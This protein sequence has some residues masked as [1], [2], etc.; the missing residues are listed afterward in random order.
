MVDLAA[1]LEALQ[2]ENEMLHR[3]NLTLQSALV[4]RSSE[5]VL[6][7]APR[8]ATDST[9]S[10]SGQARSFSARAK[11][12]LCS[13][14]A[15]GPRCTVALHAAREFLSSNTSQ[16]FTCLRD[17]WSPA[18]GGRRAPNRLFTTPSLVSQLAWPCCVSARGISPSLPACTRPGGRGQRGY[19]Q[20]LMCRR[21]LYLMPVAARAQ[22]AWLPWNGRGSVYEM[23][24]TL[25]EA[26]PAGRPNGQPGQLPAAT[27]V[28]PSRLLA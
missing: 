1:Q 16:A 10:T 8:P 28:R 25:V 12:C 4:V 19:F 22:A 9:V 27:L 21:P 18:Q 7:P 6:Q 5:S 2:H 3:Q 15:C 26:L 20:M 23:A 24:T 14:E 11:P 13:L 17:N